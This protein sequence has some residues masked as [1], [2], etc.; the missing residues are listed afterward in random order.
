MVAIIQ[1]ILKDI[2]QG[3]HWLRVTQ[4]SIEAFETKS[5]ERKPIGCAQYESNC[6][7]FGQYSSEVLNILLLTLATR[8]TAVW[9]RNF[10]FNILG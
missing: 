8:P 1:Y 2:G 6:P 5:M 9:F 4:A 3:K 10:R 7:Q